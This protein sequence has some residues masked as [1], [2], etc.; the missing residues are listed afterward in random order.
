MKQFGT[1]QETFLARN[2]DEPS[3]EE[4]KED[5][6]PNRNKNLI[7]PLQGSYSLSNTFHPPP[8]PSLRN[9]SKSKTH[10][11]ITSPEIASAKEPGENSPFTISVYSD[12]PVQQA[13]NLSKKPK[14]FKPRNSRTLELGQK[15]TILESPKVTYTEVMD[16]RAKFGFNVNGNNLLEEHMRKRNSTVIPFVKKFMSKLKN[17]SSFRNIAQ[18]KWSNFQLLNDASYYHD[19]VIKEQSLAEAT[20]FPKIWLQIKSIYESQIYH[21]KKLCCLRY[22]KDF[23]SRYRTVF[24]PYQTIKIL[25]D[26]CHLII[27]VFWFFYIPLLMAFE[28]VHDQEYSQQY[29]ISFLTSL[30]LI[31]D[32]LIN[33]NTAYFKN[34][35]VERRRSK[36][37]KN[38]LHTRFSYDLFTCLPI[39]FDWIFSIYSYNLGFTDYRSYRPFHYMKFLFFMKFSTFREISNRILEK[40]LL[41]EKF[42]NMLALCKVFFISIL[43]AHLFACFWYLTADISNSHRTWLMQS[44]INDASWQTQYLYS[45]Y[46]ASITMMTVGYGDITPQNETETVVCL[47][48]V[49]LGC[50]VYAYNINSI[51]MILQDLNKES[52]SFNH[53]I[54]IINQFME[55]KKIHTDLQM[56]IREYLRFIWK[57]ENAQNLEE[58]QKIIELLSSSLKEELLIEAYGSVLKKYPMF[59][60]NFSEN[61][62]R[63]VVTIIKDIKLIP[64]ENIFL[65]NEED[66]LCIFFIMKGSVELFANNGETPL[67]VSKLGIGDYFGEIGFFSGKKRVLSAK[68]KDFT[69]LFSVNRGEFVKVLQENSDDFEKFCMIQDQILLYENYYPLKLRCFSCNQLGHLAGQCHLIHF[70]ADKEKVI[71]TYNF[72]V[73]QKR[74]G[75]FKRKFRKKNAL[76]TKKQ[77]ITTSNKLKKMLKKEKEDAATQ[78]QQTSSELLFSDCEEDEEEEEDND[79]DLDEDIDEDEEGGDVDLD[80]PLSEKDD[81]ES[82]NND[83]NSYKNLAQLDNQKKY[84]ISQEDFQNIEIQPDNSLSNPSQKQVL[85]LNIPKTT[86]QKRHSASASMF[87]SPNDPQI[88][89]KDLDI[90][91]RTRTKKKT[92]ESIDMHTKKRPT[93]ESSNIT[94]HSKHKTNSRT[95]LEYQQITN[96]KPQNSTESIRDMPSRNGHKSILKVTIPDKHPSLQKGTPL[97]KASIT[98]NGVV[99]RSSLASN[100][101]SNNNMVNSL[102]NLVGVSMP[103]INSTIILPNNQNI[104]STIHDPS[105][106]IFDNFDRVTNFKNYFPLN[107]CKA[108]S[109]TINQKKVPSFKYSKSMKERRKSMDARLAKYTFFLEE[110]KEKMPSAI[111]KKAAKMLKKKREGFIGKLPTFKEEEGGYKYDEEVLKEKQHKWKTK[112]YF[113]GSNEQKKM[114]FS[115]VVNLIINDPYLKKQIKK[116]RIKT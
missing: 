85:S 34:G 47:I 107:N 23:N 69:T 16:E 61:S 27:I 88:I 77:L 60:A 97:T 32:L 105:A 46:W 76:K 17:A 99:I 28:S 93:L 37:L 44:N 54:N 70:M 64:D 109:E 113:T 55:R 95:N 104:N 84:S 74:D 52:I 110:M 49:L 35:I 18:L 86:L 24:H 14:R 9:K 114:N 21:V 82:I 48:S 68:S 29:K 20:G 58:E 38:Y 11:N 31:G 98:N 12:S 41:K 80:S 75:N 73:D 25:W 2:L 10:L 33:F 108:V 102:T 63:K 67:V 83:K 103:N 56:R 13:S 50:A 100:G 87:A 39:V 42:Q 116:V 96:N 19:E 8:P 115:D 62:L 91:E 81:E 111:K 71:K 5:P 78:I 65:E 53:N 92:K 15:G 112:Q 40:F 36:I 43:V 7:E 106:K 26:I 22:F 66:T 72:Y 4:F 89:F 90:K 51:G 6:S 94:N 79:E 30:F 57:E 59:F 45:M 3:F 1:F 101:L